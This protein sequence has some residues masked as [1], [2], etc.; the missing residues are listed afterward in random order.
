MSRTSAAPEAAAAA[1]AASELKHLHGGPAQFVYGG[2]AGAVGKTI[3][4]PLARLV[5]LLQTGGADGS[6]VSAARGVLRREGLRGFFRG[7]VVDVVRGFNQNGINY[8]MYERVKAALLPFDPS[9]SG[10]CARLV[11]GG[12]SGVIAVRAA[13]RAPPIFHLFR[14]RVR[15]LT[16]MT[17][18]SPSQVGVTYPLDLV[19]TRLG[20]QTRKSQYSGTV[21]AFRQIWRA[22][23]VHGVL[24]CASSGM[25]TTRVL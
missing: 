2:V 17:A 21:D 22:D 20:A 14:V 15:A 25:R 1:A 12:V 6:V 13:P 7:N 16:A 19:R 11:A 18:R 10:A 5:I 24:R 9:D 8:V 3:G 4:A 23:G